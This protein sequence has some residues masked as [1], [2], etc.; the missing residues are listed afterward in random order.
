MPV[1][2]IALDSSL[3]EEDVTLLHGRNIL[4]K[5]IENPSA[6]HLLAEP[7]VKDFL[8]TEDMTSKQFRE[9]I[10]KMIQVDASVEQILQGSYLSSESLLLQSKNVMSELWNTRLSLDTTRTLLAMQQSSPDTKKGKSELM[11]TVA[12]VKRRWSEAVLSG[13]SK[14][15]ETIIEN[16]KIAKSFNRKLNLLKTCVISKCPKCENLMTDAEPRD[17]SS[18]ATKSKLEGI[19]ESFDLVLNVRPFD[20]SA[21]LIEVKEKTKCPNCGVEVT[22]RNSMNVTFHRLL[23]SV[24]KLW[25]GDIWFEEYLSII[26]KSLGWK[27]WP[28]VHV[29]GSSGIRHEVDVLG[30][31]NGYVLIC[32]CKTGKVAR[33][34]VF[35]FWTK[36]YDIKT[37]LSILALIG[38][39]P[40]PET[41]QFILK[42]P[43][44]TLL[45]S[46]GEKSKKDIITHLETS[47]VNRI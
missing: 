37:H 2:E 27:T 34:D 4:I 1:T 38:E 47:V 3:Q 13:L 9:S 7:E 40:E 45:E 25:E 35:N 15:D 14:L 41:R 26:L 8:S 33:H 32:E 39:L 23:D 46:L 44:V 30:V 11:K 16:E 31:K 21:R 36:T 20:K 6:K 18:K 28:H 42:N 5:L 43:S 22:P 17:L 29:L 19:S 24:K 10:E 12:Q